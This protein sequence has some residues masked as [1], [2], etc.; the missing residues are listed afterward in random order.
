MIVDNFF[1]FFW[2]W[3][4]PLMVNRFYL[5]LERFEILFSCVLGKQKK[6]IKKKKGQRLCMLILVVST[7][8][9]KAYSFFIPLFLQ[10]NK[11]HVS[12]TAWNLNLNHNLG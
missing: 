8:K 3:D 5:N 10:F 6:K 9:K 4:I 7:P 1:F 12:A 11:A 2:V